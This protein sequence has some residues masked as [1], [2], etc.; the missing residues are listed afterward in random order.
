MTHMDLEIDMSELAGRSYKCI[1]RCGVCCLCQPELLPDEITAFEVDPDLKKGLVRR[2]IAGEGSEVRTQLDLQGGCGACVFM[3]DRGCTI[4]DKRTHFCRQY[5]IHI[6]SM[7]RIQLNAN[8]SCR[9]VTQGGMSLLGYAL[10]ILKATPIARLE[11]GLAR[12]SKD[13]DEFDGLCRD[14]G[15]YQP[16]ERLVSVAGALLPM[17]GKEDG[18]GRFI[19]VIE[20]APP[21]GDMAQKDVLEVIRTAEVADDLVDEANQGNYEQFELDEIAWLP[22]YIGEDLVW[23]VFQSNDGAIDW[24]VLEEDGTLSL[25]EKLDIEGIGLLRRDADCLRLFEDYA[26]LLVSRDHTLGRAYNI[27]DAL[28]YGTDLMNVYLGVLGTTMIDL[29]W[30]ASLVGRLTGRTVIDKWLAEEGIRAFD[31]DCLD[32]ETIGLFL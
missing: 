17:L 9:G 1:D 8:L 23:N 2:P 6:H 24:M 28:D 10:N 29:W 27:C 19:T 4:Y 18:I 32:A 13:A 15:V 31:A 16:P 22:Y 5:P 26:K 7:R 14:A 30:R 11:A 12:T 25:K 21:F 20:D 3:K